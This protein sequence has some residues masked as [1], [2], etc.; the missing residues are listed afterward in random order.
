MG[1]YPQARFDSLAAKA[2]LAYGGTDI[3][4]V[5]YARRDA[6]ELQA[7]SK[8]NR[9][10]GAGVTVT[11]FPVTSYFEEWHELRSKKEDRLTSVYM[12][13]EAVRYRIE[14][15]A[16]DYGRFKFERMKPGRYF[17][18][19]FLG[20][21][22]YHQRNVLVGSSRNEYGGGTDYYQRQTYGIGN[23]RRIEAFVTVKE[24]EKTVK[25]KLH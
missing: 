22:D 5:V 18:Q 3:E 23:N 7:F 6:T 24:A 10:F 21:T 14:V 9:V 19:T 17:L 25:V 13:N 4:G 1:I 15:K 8:N 16:D 2:A 11:L 20:W 12:S